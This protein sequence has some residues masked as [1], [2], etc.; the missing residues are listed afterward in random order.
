MQLRRPA[1]LVLAL[2][3]VLA[4]CGG[5]D[6]TTDTEATVGTGAA[7]DGGLSG[8]IAISGSSTVEP[9]SALVGQQFSDANSGV[10]VTVD[11]PGTGDGF[12]LF[13]S[14][15]TDISDASRTISEE[16]I[17]LCE[18]AGIE[19]LELQ[20][21]IDGLSVLTNPANTELSCLTIADMYA[22]VGPESTGFGS[23]SDADD[24]AVEAGG[25]GGFPDAELVIT[26][27]G[28][29]SG[30]YDSF[31]EFVIADLAE[32]RGQEE[33]TRPDYTASPNDNVIIEG[34]QG[35][36]SSFGWVGF[37]FYTQN[38]D[39]VKAFEVDG[40][41]GC[42]APTA[43]TIADGSYPMSR[44][45]FIYVNTA[46]M[47]E[48]PELAAFVEHYFSD[49]GLAAVTEAGYVALDSYDEQRAAIGS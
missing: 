42:V 47:A 46:N 23:W 7:G 8:S 30:T 44:P 40:G 15:E 20:V 48:K 25:S 39:T 28:E 33:V 36:E 19:Y 6:D 1:L 22:L 14:G 12:Q 10:A 37:A 31:V 27:P 49:E 18:E 5:D 34:I 13:C 26:A 35:S 38:Q 2:A 43:E 9:I 11:G 45:L 41:E 32:E 29:E 3:M 16:E 4:A 21:G 24:L 17:G